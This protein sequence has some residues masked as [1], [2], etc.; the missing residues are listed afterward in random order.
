MSIK[1]DVQYTI[2]IVCI[3]LLAVTENRLHRHHS[4]VVIYLVY[5]LWYFLDNSL[6]GFFF[7]VS[8]Y[9]AFI[10]NVVVIIIIIA[11]CTLCLYIY[12][13][14]FCRCSMVYTVAADNTTKFNTIARQSLRFV[15]LQHVYTIIN[16]TACEHFIQ[17]L[18][19]YY[20]CCFPK[21]VIPLQLRPVI[22]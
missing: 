9:D 2:V 7:F 17:T 6:H 19:K 18:K 13:R 1:I 22:R 8:P 12:C 3:V 21:T 5:S 4:F 15:F 10:S 11:G 14:V 16:T 20:Y